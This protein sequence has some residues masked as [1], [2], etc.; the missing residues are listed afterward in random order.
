MNFADI[1]DKVAFN[2][3]LDD[4]FVE[5]Q[6]GIKPVDYLVVNNYEINNIR[7][8]HKS[9]GYLRTPEFSTKL[10]DFILTEKLTF[11]EKLIRKSKNLVNRLLHPI[12]NGE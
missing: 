7:N 6:H 11:F 9:F 5:N 3:R 12:R 4:D 10:S 2:F 1:L 8:P